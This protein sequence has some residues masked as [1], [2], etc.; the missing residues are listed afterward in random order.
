MTVEAVE[1]HINK[2]YQDL[3]PPLTTQD[4][5][6]LK[7]A[8]KN[9]G[10]H[11]PIKVS[12]RTG[13]LVIVDGHH[14]YRISQELGRE[15]KYEIRHFQDE[16]KE[17]QFIQDCNIEGRNLNLFQRGMTILKIKD[18]LT[19]IAK[20]NS[21][22]NLKQ[23][24]P[25]L[26]ID[27][28]TF[29]SREV[30]GRQGVN[31]KLGKSTGTSH[32]TI[33]KIERIMKEAP[34]VIID[35][36]TRG[37]YSVNKAFKHLQNE[38]RRKE[39]INTKSVIDL[40]SSV[41]LL[42]GDLKEKG[43]EIPDNSIDLIFTDPPYAEKDLD[44]YKDLGT[45]ANRVLKEGGSLITLVGHYALLTSGNYIAESGLK[46]I[47]E[48]ALIHTGASSMLYAYHIRVK[49]KPMLWFV[50]G[51]KPNTPNII[52]N[53]VYSTPPDK[54]LHEWEQSTVEAEHIIKGLTVGENQT[55]LDPFMGVGTFGMAALKLKRKFI[56]M[57]IDSER[58][59][60]A[61]VNLSKQ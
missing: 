36:A 39:L 43:K 20:T 1:F 60:M 13:Q 46:Y 8:I 55:V 22:S 34:Q 40:P 10:Q 44:L 7:E 26:S 29:V 51:T 42:Q 23:N 37:T 38:Q 16:S 6:D 30:L 61:K 15:P 33:R 53:L 24:Q 41:M 32:E 47:H 19:E 56:G 35:K 48:I 3:I 58:F 11:I 59:E 31:E 21:K 54:A 2:E 27:S 9:R 5:N 18:K 45:F 52:D 49:W 25:Q 28:Q 4:Y 14:R 57:E 12:D 17:I 50:K